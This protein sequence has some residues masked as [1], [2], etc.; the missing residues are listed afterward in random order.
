MV[1]L[2]ILFSFPRRLYNSYN[3]IRVASCSLKERALYQNE[4]SRSSSSEVEETHVGSLL[5]SAH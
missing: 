1:T 4:N 2:D 5:F 3:G